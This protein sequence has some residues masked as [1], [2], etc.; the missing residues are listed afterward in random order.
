MR[1]VGSP[2]ACDA[3]QLLP[4]KSPYVPVVL[5]Y[6]RMYVA[7]RQ[8][9]GQAATRLPREERAPELVYNEKRRHGTRDGN[10]Y[11]AMVGR[12]AVQ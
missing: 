1:I 10:G 6:E 8:A 3:Q 7:H 11:C 12:D 5:L 9:V 2:G 4:S